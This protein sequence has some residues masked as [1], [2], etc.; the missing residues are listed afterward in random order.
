LWELALQAK[1]WLPATRRDSRGR[2]DGRRNSVSGIL[3]ASFACLSRARPAPT[4]PAVT[5]LFCSATGFARSSARRR[6]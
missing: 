6:G 4:R 2:S 3:P 1:G 5:G